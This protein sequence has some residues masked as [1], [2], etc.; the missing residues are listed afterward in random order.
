MK[1]NKTEL[2]AKFEDIMGK[3]IQ[4]INYVNYNFF[5]FSD[6]PTF[7][8]KLKHSE[9]N[10]VMVNSI[11]NHHLTLDIQ[12]DLLGK[13]EYILALMKKDRCYKR[14]VNCIHDAYEIIFLDYM[15]EYITELGRIHS[16]NFVILKRK[17][18][19]ENDKK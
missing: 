6:I 12:V 1:I 2:M 10:V 19:I 17:V 14:C 15:G 8:S 18:D 11:H 4:D 5:D 7:A 13:T 3:Q 16:V 9:S